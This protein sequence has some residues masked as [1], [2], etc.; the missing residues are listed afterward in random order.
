MPASTEKN[1]AFER[2]RASNPMAAGA[3]P[4][5]EAT[6]ASPGILERLR[7][8][9]RAKLPDELLRESLQGARA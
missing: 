9:M 3:E 7:D 4:V 5:G 2:A 8:E 6:A 1:L